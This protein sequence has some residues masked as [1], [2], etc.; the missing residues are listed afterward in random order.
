VKTQPI[1]EKKLKNIFT[2][3]TAIIKDKDRFPLS[4]E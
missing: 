3:A 2:V 4:R 1:D